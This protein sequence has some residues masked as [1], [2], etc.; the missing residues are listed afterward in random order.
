MFLF[1][2]REPDNSASTERALCRSLITGDPG[3]RIEAH[4]CISNREGTSS[5]GRDVSSHLRE[6]ASRNGTASIFTYPWHW[7]FQASRQESTCRRMRQVRNDIPTVWK[8]RLMYQT[9]SD[10]V[11]T[12]HRESCSR[13]PTETQR[14]LHV[15]REQ[16]LP[17]PFLVSWMASKPIP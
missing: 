4:A 14:I 7:A 10:V 6:A 2:E 12:Q 15:I 1:C 3:V 8:H 13:A 9:D 17:L 5:C 11:G 16:S